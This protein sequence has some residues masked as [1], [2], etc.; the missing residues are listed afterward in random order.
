[1]KALLRQTVGLVF[2]FAAAAASAETYYLTDS[3]TASIP[4]GNEYASVT[5]VQVGTNV[6]FTVDPNDALFTSTGP[7]FG[8][9]T[10]AFNTDVSLV[11]ANINVSSPTQGANYPSNFQTDNN[12]DG[13]G[14]FSYQFDVSPNGNPLVF[15]V[16]GL[17]AS[18]LPPNDDTNWFAAHIIDF[19]YTGATGVTSAWFAG[20][21]KGGQTE[22]PLPGAVWLFGS[23]LLGLLAVGRRR[24]A[25]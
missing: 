25:A 7:N 18:F 2:A 5:L 8:V 13:F 23:A 16:P 6:Q 22:I 17:L 24:Q 15:T 20:S 12:A 9:A 19:T 14:T 3:N 21:G 10:F 11:L 4:D 1:M